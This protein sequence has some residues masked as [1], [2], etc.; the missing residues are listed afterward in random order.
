MEENAQTIDGQALVNCD[1]I[2]LIT[3][4][5]TDQKNWG[6]A[7]FEEMGDG[8]LK[9]SLNPADLDAFDEVQAL[10]EKPLDQALTDLLDSCRMIGNDWYIVPPEDIGALTSSPIIGA[11]AIHAEEGDQDRPMDY[12]LVWWFPDYQVVD[13]IEVLLKHGSVTFVS[14]GWLL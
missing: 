10:L 13:P 1:R 3:M 2:D 7:L 4:R 6:P 5:P 14:A 12:A 8:S 11:G 9:I